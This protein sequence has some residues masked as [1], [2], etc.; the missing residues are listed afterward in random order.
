MKRDLPTLPTNSNNKKKTAKREIILISLRL[1][2]DTTVWITKV[3][4]PMLEV[5]EPQRNRLQGSSISHRKRLHPSFDFDM[6]AI[7]N[8]DLGL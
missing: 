1:I 8:N 4:W 3:E 7:K 5:V 2:S 6:T